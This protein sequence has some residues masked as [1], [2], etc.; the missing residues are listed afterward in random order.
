[1]TLLTKKVVSEVD[2]F[3]EFVL[4]LYPNDKP[5]KHPKYRLSSNMKGDIISLDTKDKNLIKYAKDIG[6]T[7]K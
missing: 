5:E 3:N 2:N 1:M 4:T 6:L 7:E